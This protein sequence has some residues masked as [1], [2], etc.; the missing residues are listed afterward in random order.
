MMGK[1]R[2]LLQQ[3]VEPS[4]PQLVENSINLSNICPEQVDLQRLIPQSN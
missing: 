4:I 2:L 1:S 3:G